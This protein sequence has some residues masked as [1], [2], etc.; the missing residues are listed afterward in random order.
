MAPVQVPF[1]SRLLVPIQLQADSE[2][3]LH[4]Q[5]YGQ[6]RAAILEGRLERG[7]RLPSTRALAT[8]LR[9][10]RNTVL[11]AFDQLLAEGYLDAHVGSG[12]RVA[13]A[14]PEDRVASASP[15][16]GD[17]G[18]R[19]G[20]SARG[21]LLASTPV[22]VGRRPTDA[23]AGAARAFRAGVPDLEAFPFAVWSRLAARRWRDP[24]QAL[25]DYADPAG[26]WP[27]RE[28][29][30]R[31]LVTVRAVRCE[32][33]QVLIV[34]G[35]QQ[36]L[37]VAARVLLD[38]GDVVWME[39]PGYAGARGALIAA[40]ADVCP[41]PVGPLGLEVDAG[42]ALAPAARLAYVTPSHQYPLG[43]AMPLAQR[44]AL[45]EWAHSADAWILEDDY[46]SEYRY[47]NRPLAALQGLDDDGR[48]VYIGSFSKVLF[49]GLRLGY[50]VAPHA[51]V[52]ALTATRAL[53]D[54]HPPTVDQAVLADFIAQH[55]FER[56]LHR[57]RALYAERQAALVSEARQRLAGRLE[58]APA[59]TGMHLVGW[60]EGSPGDSSDTRAAEAAS[61]AG[62]EVQPLS[63]YTRGAP[64][65][66]GLVL[67]Y[68]AVPIDEIRDGVRRL[69]RALAG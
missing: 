26:Y 10:S 31:Y 63:A 9:V 45:L 17:Q 32:P 54:R 14:P 20:P 57:M 29:I 41:V 11:N 69:A 37:D 30:A 44:L 21:R 58:V 15:L 3:P 66:P 25:L 60:L 68:A 5:I 39:D 46:D 42:R 33:E 24:P 12:T 2:R 6:L 64:I 38:P 27:L 23:P 52:Q 7:T 65:Q 36:A 48:V 62:L 18:A 4:R 28:A 35:S 16:T 47:A 61:A 50:L 8:Q 34:S 1:S 53:V 56:H 40:G 19:R 55:H 43:V 59:D 22:S 13:A 51:L 49:P 67:G